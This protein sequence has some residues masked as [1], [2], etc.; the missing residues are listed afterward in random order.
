MA[1]SLE[2]R[3][4]VVQEVDNGPGLGAQWQILIRTFDVETVEECHILRVLQFLEIR[5]RLLAQTRSNAAELPLLEALLEWSSPGFDS[6]RARCQ[7]QEQ[8]IA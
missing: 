1:N 3:G 7:T 2:I 5:E 8:N 4:I 6:R